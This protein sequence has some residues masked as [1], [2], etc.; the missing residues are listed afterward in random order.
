MPKTR[1]AGRLGVSRQTVY[2]HLNRREPF[3]KPGPA[4]AS[5]LDRFRDYIRARLERFD[6]PAT[7]PYRELGER[8]YSGGFKIFREFVRS[9][10]AGH[11]QR[12]TERFETLP[13]QQAQLD[14]GGCGTIHVDGEARTLRVRP[15]QGRTSTLRSSLHVCNL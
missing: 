11:I 6:L 4:R 5:K 12:V 8:G 3:P 15:R 13:G 10:K 1:I 9:I 7:V 2:N 14:W